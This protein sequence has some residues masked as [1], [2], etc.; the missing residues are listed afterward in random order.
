VERRFYGVASAMVST[1]RLLGQILSM[2]LVLMVFAIL[3]G[4]AKI[5]PANYPM[6]QL[7]IDTVFSIG[8]ALCIVG[9]FVSLAGGKQ[10]ATPNSTT[11]F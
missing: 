2:G 6:L 4:V 5:A 3:I 11:H 1:M 8:T 10:Q 9:I 7:S